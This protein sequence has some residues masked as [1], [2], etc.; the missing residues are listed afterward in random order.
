MNLKSLMVPVLAMASLAPAPAIA[1]TY[2]Y[3]Q[4]SNVH[5]RYVR[6]RNHKT[7]KRVGIGTAGGA[8]IG[9]LAGGGKGAGIGAIAGAGAGFLYDKHEKNK[10]R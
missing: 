5:R 7:L 6:H 8:A 3:N 4:H 1:Q 10:G 9:A 2:R